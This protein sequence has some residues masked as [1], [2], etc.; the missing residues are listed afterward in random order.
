MVSTSWAAQLHMNLSNMLS[1]SQLTLHRTI[2][3]IAVAQICF[4]SVCSRA[5][6]VSTHTS[7][8]NRTRGLPPLEEVDRFVLTNS[9]QLQVCQ[10]DYNSNRND[11]SPES[12]PPSLLDLQDFKTVRGWIICSAAGSRYKKFLPGGGVRLLSGENIYGAGPDFMARSLQDAAAMYWQSALAHLLS[13]RE[14]FKTKFMSFMT[15][16]HNC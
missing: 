13:G 6:P 7:Q 10:Y 16:L 11:Q 9:A 4:S 14:K 2:T 1:Q 15:R 5:L 8:D 12:R 3:H